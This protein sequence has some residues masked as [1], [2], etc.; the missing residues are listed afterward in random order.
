M[1]KLNE[2]TKQQ[3][4]DEKIFVAKIVD[5]IK[6]VQ[7]KNR[8]ENAA[9][10]K[11]LKE[12]IGVDKFIVIIA[13]EDIEEIKNRYSGPSYYWEMIDNLNII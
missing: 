12:A 6:S 4:D 8:Y 3:K 5:K 9:Y 13:R 1:D 2:L 11:F 7:A 10:T